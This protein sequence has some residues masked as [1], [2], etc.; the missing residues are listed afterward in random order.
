[1]FL[2]FGENNPR[3]TGQLCGVLQFKRAR[4]FRRGGPARLLGGL[5]S[6]STPALGALRGG[7]RQVHVRP[8]GDDRDDLRDAEFS[9]FFDG[10]F[11][12]VELENSEQECDGWRGRGEDFFAQ[13]ELDPAVVNGDNAAAA[14]FRIGG[15]IEFLADLGA[16]DADEVVGMTAGEG[17]AVGGSLVGDPSATGH[18]SIAVMSWLS[19]ECKACAKIFFCPSGAGYLFLVL[20]HGSHRGLNS[21]P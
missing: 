15:D 13:F 19:P 3:P 18:G 20:A 12:A 4:D 16:Q 2:G 7:S 10:P 17:G 21:S 8:A 5:E 1:M 11:H 6:D 9:A 14:D